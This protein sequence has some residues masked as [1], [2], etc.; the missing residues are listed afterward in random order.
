MS[1]AWRMADG[2]TMSEA[3][4]CEMEERA[5]KEY[6]LQQLILSISYLDIS[7][8]ISRWLAPFWS[9][10]HVH[11]SHTDPAALVPLLSEL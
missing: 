7:D 10:L 6:L 8:P 9:T 5:T 4:D 2:L 11:V 1:V 3:S